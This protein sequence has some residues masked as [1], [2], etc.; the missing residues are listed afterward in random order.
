MPSACVAHTSPLPPP[1]SLAAADSCAAR[2]SLRLAGM[3]CSK[4]Q[5]CAAS[6]AI[7]IPAHP[8]CVPAESWC[9]AHAPRLPPPVTFQHVIQCCPVHAGGLHDYRLDSAV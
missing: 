9:V 4:A 6:A 7:G 1:D 2:E 8:F 3:P 5:R